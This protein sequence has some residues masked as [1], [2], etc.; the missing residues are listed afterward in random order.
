MLEELGKQLKEALRDLPSIPNFDQSAQINGET[1]P[2][3]RLNEERGLKQ[4]EAAIQ[5]LD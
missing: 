2:T 5:E 4:I 1:S 3:E